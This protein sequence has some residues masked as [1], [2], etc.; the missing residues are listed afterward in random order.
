MFQLS[1]QI[2]I[3]AGMKT[4]IFGFPKQLCFLTNTKSHELLSILCFFPLL[5]SFAPKLAQ[6][7]VFIRTNHVP[8]LSKG[9]GRVPLPV[10][11][12]QP[13]DKAV[14]G[15]DAY[16]SA[17]RAASQAAWE[18]NFQKGSRLLVKSTTFKTLSKSIY[19]NCFKKPVRLKTTKQPLC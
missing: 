1:V 15:L 18:A 7:I 2:N 4:Y 3:Q 6:N 8:E 17:P 12:R 19:F 14:L 16:S 5:F 13:S 11:K 10:W 9:L